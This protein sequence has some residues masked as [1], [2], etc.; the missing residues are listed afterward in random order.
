MIVSYSLKMII[1][2]WSSRNHT[3]KSKLDPLNDKSIVNLVKELKKL[4]FDTI[5]SIGNLEENNIGSNCG[6]YITLANNEKSAVN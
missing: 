1:R 5:V 3:L 4:N 2:F 6:Q